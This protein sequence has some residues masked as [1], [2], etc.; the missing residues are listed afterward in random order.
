[1]NTPKAVSALSALAQDTR[2]AIF[3]ALVQRGPEGMS[4]GSIGEA[5]KMIPSSLSFHLALLAKAGLVRQRRESR[6]LI[7]TAN[8]EAMTAAA[9]MPAVL[10]ACPPARPAPPPPSLRRPVMKRLH[11]HVA[12][13]D[14]DNSIAFYSVLFGAKPT[15]A[16]PDY[17]KWMLDDPRV[18]FAISTHG[19]V[20]LD[21]LGIQVESEA[22][23][24]DVT[25]RLRAAN[26]PIRDEGK[27]TCCYAESDKAWSND[28]SGL[29]WETFLTLGEAT[30]YG[31]PRGSAA[32]EPEQPTA[33]CAVSPQA[34]ATK[35]AAPCC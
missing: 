23:L 30:T 24:V 25:D 29:A 15:V 2:L 19:G 9:E 20:G 17:A 5:V 22:E 11:V 34:A 14:L 18:N 32:P 28:P 7:Y 3:R 21:H 8:F 27:T 13:S 1:M 26:A 12:V 16:K 4:A 31:T 6:N 33:C 10:S 35:A